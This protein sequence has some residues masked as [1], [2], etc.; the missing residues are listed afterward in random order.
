MLFRSQEIAVVEVT[1]A[2]HFIYRRNGISDARHKLSSKLKAQIHALGTDV[3]QQV[4]RRRDRMA[5][6]SANLLEWMQV[7][8]SRRPKEAVPRGRPKP[9][10]A[11]KAPCQIAKFYRPHQRGEVSAELAHGGAIVNAR[12]DRRDQEDRGAGK[13]RGYCLCEGR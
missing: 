11:G 9:H 13:R 5:I 10:D 3:E 6:S 1:E 2:V 8:G 12:V 7:C 4:S